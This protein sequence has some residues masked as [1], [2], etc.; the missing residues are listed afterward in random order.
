MVALTALAALIFLWLTWVYLVRQRYVAPWQGLVIVTVVALNWRTVILATSLYTEMVYAA[1]SVA[2]LILAEKIESGSSGR[3]AGSVL[4]LLIGFAFL[5]R[6]SGAAL[7]GS[8]AIFFFFSRRI[9]RAWMPLA[10]GALFL[11]VWVG[12][13]YANR[14][15]AKG[16]NVAYYTSYFGHLKEVVL[17]LTAQNHTSVPITIVG[18]L[19]TNA[20]ML[21][22]VS[23]PLVCFGLNLNWGLYL[24]FGFLLVIAGFVRDVSRGWRLIHV[25]V[26]G[27]LA[28]HLLWLPF[29][30]YDRFLMPILPFLLLLLFREFDAMA[31]HAREVLSPNPFTRKASALTV[32]L[33]LLGAISVGTFG[34]A[35]NLFRL[36]ASA[37]VDKTVRPSPENL[38]SIQWI[39]TNTK[40]SDV[41]VCDRDPMY[42]LYTGRKTVHFL[43]MSPAIDWEKDP[44][45]VFEILNQNNGKYLILTE[46]DFEF[47]F[48]K[49]LAEARPDQFVPV[50]ISRN[51]RGAVYRITGPRSTSDPHANTHHSINEGLDE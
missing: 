28:L 36:L 3:L 39:L 33:V 10:I 29:V 32:G 25:Y 6:S 5:T 22:V 45:P 35:S 26:L 38:E 11:A 13:S 50:F 34:Y 15:T 40:D 23:V 1:L 20:F 12:W 19:A 2:A 42:Y 9:R 47:K 27:Y 18:S 16:I 30:S 43:P 49:N 31:S 4:G 51:G 48:L 41:L 14:P 21:I 7:L 8:I 44:Q 17:D 46:S 24:A 37:P